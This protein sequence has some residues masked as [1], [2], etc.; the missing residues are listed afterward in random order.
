MRSNATMK[1]LVAY[2][3]YVMK[4]ETTNKYT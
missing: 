2:N 1:Q 3:V 4:N